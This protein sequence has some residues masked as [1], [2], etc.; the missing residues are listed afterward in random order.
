M[1]A[2]ADILDGTVLAEKD[3]T[4]SGEGDPLVYIYHTHSQEGYADS[5]SGD[6][7]MSV[8]ALGDRL[9]EILTE[10][11]GLSVLHNPYAYDIVEGEEEQAAHTMTRRRIWRRFWRSIHR[12]R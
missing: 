7:S 4:L 6:A 2:R 1:L 5:K 3:L 9:T 12:F 11:Y 8:I 10:E